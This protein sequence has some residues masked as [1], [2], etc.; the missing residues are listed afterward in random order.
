MGIALLVYNLLLI[1]LFL[2]YPA[3]LAWAIICKKESLR[4]RL[5]RIKGP[6]PSR[7][8]WI[9]AASVGEVK[10]AAVLI[11]KIRARDPQRQIV[12]STVTATGQKEA[13]KIEGLA[14]T[15]YFPFDFIILLWPLLR[16]MKASKLILIETEIWPNLIW[17]ASRQGIKIYLANARL[18]TKSFPRYRALR[19]FFAPLL[20]RFSAICV[21]SQENSC[22][23][24]AL[25]V[26]ESLVYFPGNIKVDGVQINTSYEIKGDLAAFS[27]LDGYPL[28]VGGSTHDGE[29]EALLTVYK[30][31]QQKY[32]AL[33]MVLAPRH[34]ERSKEVLAMV[35]KHGFNAIR[36]TEISKDQKAPVIILDTIGELLY[37][38]ARADIVFIGGSLVKR[39]GHN[40]LEAL[41]KPI[42]FGPH[43]DNCREIAGFLVEEN[44]ARRVQGAAELLAEMEKILAGRAA[45]VTS[46]SE[47]ARAF[48]TT[49]SGAAQ[50]TLD[51]IFG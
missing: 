37:F 22:R 33:H 2:F 14:N 9:H 32:P 11:E 34:T 30:A 31:L 42:F 10:V 25:G 38:Y 49:H 7:A 45:W 23:F 47:K 17:L 8:I 21:Q 19:F 5:G 1:P 28:I 26:K 6:L 40:P 50:K 27:Y 13:K 29:E 16:K 39:G 36:R 15:F 35:A 12:L 41:G 20:N 4:Y 18:G 51:I 3:Y 46:V 48:L 44:L 43:T 24:K